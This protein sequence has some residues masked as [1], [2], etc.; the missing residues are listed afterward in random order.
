MVVHIV[1]PDGRY[2]GLYLSNFATLN[3]KDELARLDGV[4]QAQAF[5]AGNYAMRIWIDP[6]QAAQHG[7]TAIDIMGAVREPAVLAECI[8]VSKE[9]IAGEYY[10][11]L[12]RCRKLMSYEA[13]RL[14]LGHVD[15][16]APARGHAG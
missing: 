5:G 10:R 8:G 4:G 13:E 1:S 6:D 12:M 15:Q 11:A 14:G 2:D 7:L 3:V 9:V 16:S